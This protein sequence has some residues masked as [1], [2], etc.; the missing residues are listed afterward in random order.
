MRRRLSSGVGW[1]GE[2]TI[3]TGAGHA[4]GVRVGPVVAV[5]A[6][7]GGGPLVGGAAVHGALYA[8]VIPLGGLK[9]AGLARCNHR[10]GQGEQAN[11]QSTFTSSG[12]TTTE[13]S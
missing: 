4:D 13:E 6:D 7:A 12:S 10:E 5:S 3:R 2:G 11:I 1:G 8:G 9:V